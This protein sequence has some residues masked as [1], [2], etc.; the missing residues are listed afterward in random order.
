MKESKQKYR[1]RMY[2]LWN[3]MG[4]FEIKEQNLAWQ[5][6]SIFENKRL[7][8]IEIQQLRKEIKKDEIVPDRVDAMSEMSYGGSSG[9]E[10]FKEQCCNLGD[11]PGNTP[12]DDI[13]NP[14]H[15]HRSEIMHERAKGDI[16]TLGSR[17]ITFVTKYVHEVN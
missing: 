6:W 3:E 11:Y 2:D 4:M 1:K 8:E 15:Q 14:I 13:N 7:T 12:E 17:D 9:T 5:V 16:S 10:T